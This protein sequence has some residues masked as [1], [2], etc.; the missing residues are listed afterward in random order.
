MSA[1]AKRAA[2]R[3]A[4]KEI[5]DNHAAVSTVEQITATMS[6][7][8]ASTAAAAITHTGELKSASSAAAAAVAEPAAPVST[9]PR[10]VLKEKGNR[11][12][13]EKNM[14]DAIR[15][16]TEAIDFAPITEDTDAVAA[17]A[18][19]ANGSTAFVPPFL[20]SVHSNR[21]AAY[22]ACYEWNAA[23]SDA[24][25]AVALA[26]KWAKGHYRRGQALEG[27]MK[28]D[29]A[30]AAYAEG[31]KLDPND[32]ILQRQLDNLTA[33]ITEVNTVTAEEASENPE[34]DIW[35]QLIDWLVQG[36][37]RFPN[38]YLKYYSEDYRG[39]HSHGSIHKDDIVLEVPLSHIM[40]SEV[41]KA[42][43]IGQRILNS[44]VDLN[45]THTYLSC[46]L[47][48]ERRNPYSFWTPYIKC[49]PVHY[50]NMPIFFTNEELAYLK[51][52]FSLGK[53]ADR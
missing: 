28:Y 50:R 23:V 41:A 38:L 49:L 19:A 43:D 3:K 1:A 35:V 6:V 46:Y 37:S 45:S 21:S 26:P 14:A 40:T 15:Y 53:I 52:S 5:E 9:D 27:L 8:G 33:I 34:S 48:Q 12:F 4:K 31:A 2:K 30:R 42:S 47:L 16:F 18:A 20:A 44:G 7:A 25:R 10:V 36:K 22:A 24:D 17:K 32:L 13:G 29:A 39:V 51:G 11:A